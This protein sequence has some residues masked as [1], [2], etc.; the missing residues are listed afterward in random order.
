M[1]HYPD[2]RNQLNHVVT[3]EPMN[4]RERLQATLGSAYAIERE[5]GGGGMSR[6]FV[7]EEIALGRKVAV[8]VL[9]P[10][11]SAA[12]NV[13]RFKREI[14]LAAT[15]QH[16]HI[17]PVHST[18]EMDGIPYFTMPFIEGESLRSRL[19]R[20]EVIPLREVVR[21][22]QEVIGA[23]AY[24]HERG[25]VHRDIKPDN[26]LMNRGHAVVTDF[27]VAKAISVAGQA[28][29]SGTQTGIGVAIGTPAYMAPEQAAGDPATDHRADIYSFGLLAY[30]L[31][32]GRT[33]F[34]DR[35]PHEL[36]TAHIA[37]PPPPLEPVQAD[38][39]PS[40]IALVMRCL[41]KKPA[42]R[43]QT[44]AEVRELLDAL[45]TISGARHSVSLGAFG[46]KAA[47]VL[48]IA[49]LATGAIVFDA[50]RSRPKALDEQV[51]AVLP[52]RLTG[53]DPS[54]GYLREGMLDLLAAKLT[55]EGGPRSSDPRAILSA[56][57]SEVGSDEIDLPRDRA[58][59]MAE[60][61][62]AGQ[63]LLGDVGGNSSRVI[64]NATLLRV[65][66]GRAR[67]QAHV[68]GPTD[69]LAKLV[70]QL[71][72]QLLAGGAGESERLER[73]TSTSL[74][75]LRAYLDAQTSYR[76]GRYPASTREFE[77]ALQ[78][79]STFA[80]AA[81]GLVKAASWFGDAQTAHRGSVIAWRERDRLSERDRALLAATVGPN[82]PRPSSYS[83]LLAARERY[84][85]M[86]PDRPEAWFDFGDGLFHFGPVV[87][88]ADAPRRAA[89]A[90]RRTI[91][92]D[93]T[94]APAI[95]HLLLIEARGGDTAEVRR[96]GEMFLRADSASANADG[97]RW[98][99]AVATGDRDLLAD[100]IR[101][102]ETLTPISS[103][104]I[105]FVS[106]LEGIDLDNAQL[107]LDASA[108]AA[109]TDQDRSQYAQ[110]QHHMALNRGR[111]AAAVRASES[112]LRLQPNPYG[113]LRQRI[114]DALFWDGDSVAA[115]IA[116][117]ELRLVQ[118]AG[119]EK[120]L[121]RAATACALA[122]WDL[123]Q[124]VTGSTDSAI[125]LSREALASADSLAALTFSP[126]CIGILETW[127]SHAE[128][129]PDAARRLVQL[130][131]ILLTGPGGAIQEVGNL[132]VAR[133]RSQ[134]G[135][136]SGALAALRRR[137][138]FFGAGSLLSTYAREEGRLLALMGDTAG[139]LGA[140]RYY[141][142]LR[143]DPEP[144]LAPE[145]ARVRRE[146]QRLQQRSR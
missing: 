80:L 20:G 47:A 52:F 21:I 136:H 8:K 46:W 68:E 79:D 58:L 51:V 75:A 88:R 53:A 71:T 32:G 73:L 113:V 24:A 98:R 29:G 138:Y 3:P 110:F 94:F 143:S 127:R 65:S 74:P 9:P 121:A 137:E 57:R 45:P 108:D 17:V 107:V 59:A 81:L 139:A 56:W 34:G 96:L 4:F 36:L 30:E 44:A 76:H 70:D 120:P 90:F 43:P 129:R 22:L 31:L 105:H 78:L 142:T 89:D 93:S 99:M 25:V 102:R 55:G 135:D 141:L 48:L 77:R 87:G 38:V 67:V 28:A 62:G 16:P 64:L 112:G 145:V 2:S 18:G 82:F 133:F 42:N 91:A 5:L 128:R 19:S 123:S 37:E 100:V 95:E 66:D 122:Q 33:P 132:V 97:V 101:R 11:L 35:S 86:A 83:E 114:R 131:S 39:P 60:R 117:R 7:A 92:L 40:L 13:E 54:L 6:V 1:A 14:M 72:A 126:T 103:H 15:L 84:L 50:M 41:E 124:G 12:V 140:Y 69:S 104:T 109:E 125:A 61:L 119:L 106:Q 144:A 118:E 116:A 111:P 27:G 85:A 49:V 130:D 10:D 146:V 23:L 26:I 134:A 115:D 63:L